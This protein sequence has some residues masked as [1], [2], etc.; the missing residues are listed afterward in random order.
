M[1]QSQSLGRQDSGSFS[2]STNANPSDMMA[3]SASATEAA[4]NDPLPLEC[5]DATGEQPLIGGNI[6]GP[7]P[8]CAR[9]HAEARCQVDSV[10]SDGHFTCSRDAD[11]VALPACV[12]CYSYAIVST[13]SAEGVK[14]KLDAVCDAFTESGC[15]QIPSGCPFVARGHGCVTGEC[16]ALWGCPLGSHQAQQTLEGSRAIL[17]EGCESDADCEMVRLEGCA[18]DCPLEFAVAQKQRD[19]LTQLNDAVQNACVGTLSNCEPPTTCASGV[20]D[21]R[22]DQ[23]S[24][25]LGQCS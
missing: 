8:L 6:R 21:A 15:S 4:S 20:A 17:A 9:L 12:D 5:L 23:G 14:A 13:V 16:Q 18:W 7:E 25:T 22:C 24:C 19:K 2:T 1:E 10:N 3:P 11:C